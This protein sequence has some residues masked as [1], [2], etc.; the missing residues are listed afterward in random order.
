[1]ML[2]RVADSLYW[3]GRYIERAEH[4]CRL[5]DVLLLAALDQNE[6]AVALARSAARAFDDKEA[7]DPINPQEA[8]RRLFFD[9]VE[10]GSAVVSLTRARENAR[11]VRD[12][13]TT[14]TWE[15]LNLLYLR[16]TSAAAERTFARGAGGYLHGVIADLHL[17]KGALDT[18]MS[19]GEGWRFLQLGVHLERAQLIAR[20]LNVC[21]GDRAPISPADDYPVQMA[22]LRMACALEP[23]LRVYTADIRPRFLL[24]FLLF[25]KEFPRS[26]RFSTQR[27]EEHLG[28]IGRPGGWS[29]PSRPERLAAR[30]SARL[31]FADMEDI[32]APGP[33][34]SSV[35]EECAAIHDAIYETFVS[36]PLE[37]RLPA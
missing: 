14:E 28:A 33:L 27:V 5:A 18:T 11:Q 32:F 29:G 37:Q 26:I 17:F 35:N 22:V 21:F 19:H 7:G 23:Y 8:V 13:I 31:E 24:E 9:R 6:A 12:H 2:A 16:V 1:M 30:L 34:L 3:I 4:R 25:D 36:Y 20:L 10:R 15:R